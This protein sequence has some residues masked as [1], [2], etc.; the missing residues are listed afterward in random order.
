MR[1]LFL[2]NNDWIPYTIIHKL[3]PQLISKK[4]YDTV[5]IFISDC[6]QIMTVL[7]FNHNFLFQAN[8][9]GLYVS[10]AN[11]IRFYFL[12]L[13]FLDQIILREIVWMATDSFSGI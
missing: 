3:F 7:Y 5:L 11:I 4:N 8:C 6:D 10:N 9:S 1:N 2:H 13:D 12:L